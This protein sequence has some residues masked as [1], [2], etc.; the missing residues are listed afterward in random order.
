VA[1]LFAALAFGGLAVP[2]FAA[3]GQPG[4]TA[5][6]EAAAVPNS[7]TA[8]TQAAA[9]AGVLTC[10]GRIDQVARFLGAG[11]QI[12]FLFLMPSP[13]RDQRLVAS[14]MEIDNKDV[15]SAY[16]S[17]EFAPSAQGCGASY[18]TV[19]YWPV[20][21]EAAVARYFAGV[22]KAPAL[23]KSIAALDPG[24]NARIFLM[25]AGSDGCITI[26]KELHG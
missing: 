22:R 7:T 20:S 23:G 14:A 4:G 26:K 9:Q 15:P 12:S 18:E 17:A 24:G 19:T 3:G 8:M 16:A 25:P 5:S 13:P 6:D 21:C 10:A 1:G 11:N 2:A